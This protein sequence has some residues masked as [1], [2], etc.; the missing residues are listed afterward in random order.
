MNIRVSR[1]KNAIKKFA[2]IL[3]PTLMILSSSVVAGNAIRI[4]KDGKEYIF[5][6]PT[7]TTGDRKV[8]VIRVGFEDYSAD[9]EEYPADSE[10]ALLSYF[11]GSEDS[12]NAFYKTSSYGKLN[13]ICDKVYTYNAPNERY[14]YEY[15]IDKLIAEAIDYFG[16]EI[17]LNDYDSDS[18]GILDYVC[19]DFSG[20]VGEWASTWWPHVDIQA[21]ITVGDK[22]I[23]IY[24]LLQAD[25]IT[26]THEFG[27]IMGA[28]DYY[29]Y[30]G[31]HNN[32]IMTYDMMGKNIGD[33]DGFTKWSFGWFDDDDIE[34]VDKSS[35]DTTVNLTP[36]EYGLG[37]GKKIA[38]VSP[39]IDRS[40]GFLDEFF[41]VEYDSGE[42]NNASAFE[43]YSLEPGFRIFHV[44]AKTKFGDIETINFSKDNTAIRNNLIHNVKN[45]LEDPSD[46]SST[47]NF[48]REGDSLTVDGYPNTG[49]ETEGIYNG[50]FTGINFTDFVTG[51]NPS[52]K[53]SF[54]DEYTPQDQVSLTVS[55][56][57]LKS[58]I[59][60]LVEADQ[61]ITAVSGEFVEDAD[62]LTPYL[63][64]G[65]GN[66]FML[67]DDNEDLPAN[68][69][70]LIYNGESYPYVLPNTEYTL[71]IPEGFF[72]TG[73]NVPV[74]EVRAQ[75]KTGDFMTLKT[76]GIFPD[77]RENTLFS[78]PFAITDSTYGMISFDRRE[79]KKFTM[80]EYDENGEEVSSLEFDSPVT[81]DDEVYVNGCF[82]TKLYDGNFGLFI[83]S[84]NSNCFVK[85]DRDGNAISDVFEVDGETV[86]EYVSTFL[87]LDFEPYKNGMCALLNSSEG[88][89]T[90]L[91]TVDFENEP[92]ITELEEGSSY[93]SIDA[94]AYYIQK[95]GG[96][97][98]DIYVYNSSDEQIAKISTDESFIGAL[99]NDGNIT[100]IYK[101]LNPATKEIIIYADTY[102][103]EGVL[104]DRKDISE[105]AF[106]LDDIS[107]DNYIY[108]ADNYYCVEYGDSDNQFI[109]LYDK[110][111]NNR[112]R[113]KNTNIRKLEYVGDYAVFKLDNYVESLSGMR[114]LILKVD[115]NVSETEPEQEETTEPEQTNAADASEETTA[116]T[117][118][119]TNEAAETT[120]H[121]ATVPAA[122]NSDAKS[123]TSDSA[124]GTSNN[125]AVKTGESSFAVTILLILIT[126]VGF[127]FFYRRQTNTNS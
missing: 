75:V 123:S 80:T 6:S 127:M 83:G 40:N 26:Y 70:Y 96:D 34:F 99:S 14:D 102:S 120:V 51:D 42:G 58:Y 94:N 101:S 41:V 81:Y 103:R 5:A 72:R 121:S 78:N 13:L 17:N 28:A 29:S 60:I 64:D 84:N 62:K 9:D 104:L 98:T 56:N 30:A 71:V 118:E 63:I 110:E 49:F 124:A 36:I 21:D 87:D 126:A 107:Q 89:M 19:F 69:Y 23:N 4:E 97:T 3:I 95:N 24:S 22:K 10:E 53:V 76:I 113:L 25:A 115:L 59:Q 86:Y 77:S 11:D 55:D 68:Q 43:E 79:A 54:S 18:D 74:D 27:H 37:D 1:H 108:S 122:N 114:A 105:N 39:Q 38:V 8:L 7:P 32:N 20:P 92:K 112:G 93:R 73:Y 116:I 91:L 44:N 31:H 12:V 47:E 117:E 90:A 106:Y 2:A 46:W 61:V 45:E 57:E 109:L 15:N 82:V 111:W 88:S 119:T 35:G 16:D 52:F 65:D 85:I 67:T 48:F 50:R 100:V 66:K 125:G 33:H